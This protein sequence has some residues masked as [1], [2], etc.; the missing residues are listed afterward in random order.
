MKQLEITFKSG[1]QV[2]VDVTEV[3]LETGA[4]DNRDRKLTWTTPAG[5]K[6]RLFKLDLESVDALVTIE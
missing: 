1:A 2:T 4:V 5:A 3:T 6:R